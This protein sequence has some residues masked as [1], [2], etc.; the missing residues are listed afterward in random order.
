[1]SWLQLSRKIYWLI[2]LT[3]KIINTSLLNQFTNCWNNY[4][5]KNPRILYWT[6][7]MFHCGIWLP[8]I[9]LLCNSIFSEIWPVHNFVWLYE[10]RHSSTSWQLW[11]PF[12]NKLII[13]LLCNMLKQDI[14]I[15][16][17]FFCS[18]QSTRFTMTIVWTQKHYILAILHVWGS[19]CCA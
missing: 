16:S 19:Q 4:G 9:V 13:A 17:I 14:S 2:F 3:A 7:A 11:N 15:Q 18:V 1:M 6:S 5:M 12:M 8:I 10:D